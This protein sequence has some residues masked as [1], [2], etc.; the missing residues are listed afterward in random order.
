MESL[1]HRLKLLPVLTGRLSDF[2]T[3]AAPDTPQALFMQWLDE[4]LESGVVEPQVTT[5]STVDAD[6][7]PDARSV[8]LLDVSEEGWHF[9]ANAA[10]PKGRQLARQ[11]RAA[12]TFY[13]PGTARQVRLRGE[14][15]PLARELGLADFRSRPEMS[16]AAI[17]A[18]RQSE[19]LEQ[20][21]DLA[22]ALAQQLA[23]LQEDPEL[24]SEHWTLYALK[25]REVEFWQSNEQRRFT[26]LC[27]RLQ[28]QQW[29]RQQLWP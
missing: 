27:Y 23:R 16:R 24:A 18:A 15:R 17:L 4:A 2:D 20:A 13:W 12:M 19:V 7:A 14:V 29:T 25:P 10:S 26:R 3:T 5:L 1:I 9:A 22:Q 21:D 28:G 6:G 11:P 8:M